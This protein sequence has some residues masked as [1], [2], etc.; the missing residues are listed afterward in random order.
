M[1]TL[2]TLD[3]LYIVLSIFTAIVWT[4]LSIV[5]YRV[6]KILWPVLE[7]LE[8]YEKVKSYLSS[9]KA[10]PWIVKEKVF[11]IISWYSSKSKDKK[12]D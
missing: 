2:T 12:E 4:L 7:I 1:I 3:L 8:Y 11:D 9:Y 6:I 10:I 5:L